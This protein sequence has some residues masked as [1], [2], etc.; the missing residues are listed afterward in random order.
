MR[1]VSIL[2]LA[3]VLAGLTAGAASAKLTP[4]EEKWVAPL[5]KIWEKQNAGL[6]L[7][8]P[9]ATRNNGAGMVAGTTENRDLV[10]IL[11]ALV[12]CKEPTDRIKKAGAPASPRLVA[13]RDALN[14]ACIH[15]ANGAH[16]FAKAIA[17][18]GKKKNTLGKSLLV[19]GVA[20]FKKGTAQISKAYKAITAVGG[21]NIF[22]A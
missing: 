5:L 15:D 3:V 16:D 4:A 12:D 9:A 14:S 22:T 19:S 2:V 8:I 17:A 10:T 7:V 13:F 21:K 18:F 20:E 11:A 1:A 6:N